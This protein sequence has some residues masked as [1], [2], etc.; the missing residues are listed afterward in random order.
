MLSKQIVDL[1]EEHFADVPVNV[2]AEV[3]K[4]IPADLPSIMGDTAAARSLRSAY[5][6]HLVS[7][8]LCRRIFERFLLSLG[9]RH[10]KSDAL[11]RAMSAELR[12]H[13]TRKE[14]VWRQH[15]LYAAYTSPT[16]KK[17]TNTA[18][19]ML[20][21]EIVREIR[22]FTAPPRLSLVHAAVRRIVKLA[23]ETWRYARLEREMI[24]VRMPKPGEAVDASPADGAD[25]WGVHDYGDLG[26]LAPAQGPRR[27]LIGLLPTLAREPMHESLRSSEEAADQGCLYSRGVALFSDCVPVRARQ[28]EVQAAS[29][30]DHTLRPSSPAPP[31]APSRP[32]S[33]LPSS[34][35]PPDKS[36]SESDDPDSDASEAESED[37]DDSDDDDH[38]QD[39]GAESPGTGHRPT[40]SP[41]PASTGGGHGQPSSS[42]SPSVRRSDVPDWSS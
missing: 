2:P 4:R 35:A 13:S 15:T 8:A 23:A 29:S 41:S 27:V 38:N 32:A 11:F 9:R 33:A 26:E 12:N 20:V 3:V 25:G 5:I 36:E 6:Q 14:A 39:E 34:P 10:E 7:S 24:T 1:S 21:E 31:Q 19:G 30:D 17:A 22:L 28:W 42:R 37:E 18:A 40:R 16:A